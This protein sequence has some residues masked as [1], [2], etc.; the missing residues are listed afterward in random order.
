[1]QSGKWRPAVGAVLGCLALAVPPVLLQP[2]ALGST[3]GAPRYINTIAGKGA[4]SYCGDGGPAVAACL[5]NPRGIAISASGNIFLADT[6]NNRIRKVNGSGNISTIAGS[7]TAGFCGDG[8]PATSACLQNPRGVAVDTSGNVFIADTANNRI[9]KVTPGGTITTIAGGGGS[10]FCGDGGPATSACLKSPRDV[11]VDTSGNVFIADTTNNRIRKVTPGG[12]ITTIAGG[13]GSGFC[14]DGGPAT[15][16]CLKV[17][18]GVAVDTAGNVHI[19]DTANNRIRKVTPGGTITTIAGQ[20]T[21]GFC[22]NGGP[23]T[24]ACLNSPR[25]VTVDSAFN[26]YI[27]DRSNNRVRKMNPFGIITTF[28][29]NGTAGFC[30]DLG[31]SVDACLRRP[32]G[33]AVDA[34]GLLLVADTSNQRLRKVGKDPIPPS[35][36]AI[37]TPTARGF[38]KA[39]RIPLTWSASDASGIDDYDIAWSGTRWNGKEYAQ[40]TWLSHR[41]KTSAKFKGSYGM[42]YCFRQRA[43]DTVGNLSNWSKATCTAIPL[44]TDHL[45]YG[46]AW[47]LVERS[48]LFAGTAIVATKKNSRMTLTGVTARKLSL[49]ASRC[50]GLRRA[51]RLLE[52][53]P[54]EEGRPALLEDLSR[55]HHR[56][57]DLVQVEDR[58]ARREGRQ[59]RRAGADRGRR[60]IQRLIPP[61]RPPPVWT[62]AEPWRRR[63]SKQGAGVSGAS[64]RLRR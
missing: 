60:H 11:A 40:R 49:V 58:Q 6:A 29:G 16:A 14:G 18:T 41:S 53:Q 31:K 37:S 43:R 27:A 20:G 42:S 19:A 59:R 2:A 44:S 9:R 61:G 25:D 3:L 30:G 48:K 57:Q 1:M 63:A 4:G 35:N 56:Y 23:A 64:R 26:V 46:S 17:P 39:K 21:E 8:G 32:Q 15:S 47:R 10:G 22:G 62:S 5:K 52:R 38:S 33:V 50:R 12:T 34:S 55:T 13:G 36:L 54:L 28:A 51:S 45:G 7:N 24:D